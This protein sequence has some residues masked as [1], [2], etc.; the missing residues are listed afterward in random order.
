MT[1]DWAKPEIY[2]ESRLA[3]VWD[4]QRGLN[5]LEFL[6]KPP[7]ED[8]KRLIWK[9][10]YGTFGFFQFVTLSNLIVQLPTFLG[11]KGNDKTSFHK[12]MEK[13]EGTNDRTNLI[14]ECRQRIDECSDPLQ[15][16][17]NLR[18]KFFGHRDPVY[19]A[20]PGLV[21][22]ENPTLWWDLEKLVNCVVEVFDKLASEV[23]V[24]IRSKEN[25]HDRIEDFFHR[26]VT[27]ENIKVRVQNAD[28]D[29]GLKTWLLFGGRG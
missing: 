2:F 12:L 25:F 24:D 10:Y 21:W 4:L 8:S 6:G 23:G 17:V 15:A 7:N 9:E 19:V 16:V 11:T 27:A 29:I 26:I 14:E 18:D 13:M 1:D 3:D 22:E 20:N 28:I 5:V